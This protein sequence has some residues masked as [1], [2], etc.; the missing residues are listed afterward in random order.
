MRKHEAL[1][2][3][4]AC[5]AALVACGPLE[6]REPV[7]VTIP[8]GA[9]IDVVAESLAVHQLVS[10]AGSFEW[11]AKFSGVTDSL[12]AGSYELYAGM[13]PAA[14]VDE[15]REGRP[16]VDSLVIPPGLWAKE[17]A[18][19][20]ERQLSVPADSFRVATHDSTLIARMETR[21]PSL[22]GY[23]FPG[24]HHVRRGATAREIVQVMV[25]AFEANW[26]LEW[27]RRL[28]VLGLSR[29]EIVTLASIVEGEGGVDTDVPYMA[30]V[31][32]NRLREGMRLQADPTVV[33][34][35]GKRRRVYN[36]DYN[37]DSPFNTYR[38]DGLPPAPIGNP[39]AATLKAVLYPEKTEFLYFVASA[40]GEHVF[41]RSYR[42]HL[43]TIR[44]IRDH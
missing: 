2:P 4:L 28:D 14:I 35:M 26:P 7:W 21:G 1:R 42:E 8:H 9:S 16:F 15:L 20:V 29:D 19:Y 33:Y 12:K 38:V 27:T 39:S 37:L 13:S 40:S 34:G 41:S 23:L 10:S 6:R 5:L 43:D 31:Y 32:H 22:E 18:W 11:Y 30:S 44:S 36:N 24:V 25:L 17:I 3:A